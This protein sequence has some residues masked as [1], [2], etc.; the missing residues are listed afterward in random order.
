ME[1]LNMADWHKW[2]IFNG[3]KKV[4]I[5]NGN[6]DNFNAGEETIIQGSNWGCVVMI[7]QV[8]HFTYKT[9]PEKVFLD[10][11][12]ESREDM[13]EGM[14]VYYPEITIEDSYTFI[15]WDKVVET[16]G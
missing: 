7:T 13:F 9:I 3:D 12:F 4:T 10:D 16:F 11:G 5:R 8:G 6:R 14:R 15:R 2:P 1:V